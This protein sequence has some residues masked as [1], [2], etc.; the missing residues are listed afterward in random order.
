VTPVDDLRRPMILPP[1]WRG[2]TPR[3]PLVEAFAR[4]R[5]LLRVQPDSARARDLRGAGTFLFQQVRR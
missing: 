1:W 3:E 4:A 2:G 5:W